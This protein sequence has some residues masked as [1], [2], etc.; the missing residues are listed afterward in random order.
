[1]KIS[2]IIPTFNS[3]TW[4]P[5]AVLS[6]LEQTHNNIEVIIVDD[7]SLDHTEQYLKFIEKDKRVKVLRNPKNMGRSASRNI[8]NLAATGD[9]ICVLDAD[10]MAQ[11]RRA[12]WT[13]EKF[14]NNGAQMI[15]GSALAIHPDGGVIKEIRA[16]SFDKKKALAS[17]VNG[18][19]HSTVAYTRQF[20]EKYPYSSGDV[21]RLGID[22]WEQQIR[23]AMDGVKF[24][25]LPQ[26]V[27]A[28]RILESGVSQQRNEADV[29]ALKKKIM[30]SLAVPA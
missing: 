21:A 14:K 1:M 30:E 26:V 9:I 13:A 12:E 28:Y 18:I 22:D 11:K 7:C 29:F 2:F 8:G 5:L 10:D 19:V 23:A 15:Y 24:D 27:S 25:Y 20:A 16:E 3:V 17:M 4:L 6:C